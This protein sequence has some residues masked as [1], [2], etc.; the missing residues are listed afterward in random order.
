MLPDCIQ[1]VTVIHQCSGE[2]TD[3]LYPKLP[4]AP[5][6]MPFV[7]RETFRWVN[8][9]SYSQTKLYYIIVIYSTL[10]SRFFLNCATVNISFGA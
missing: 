9:L 10:L 3:L 5:D 6:A 2:R 8:F 1:S 4:F 7:I